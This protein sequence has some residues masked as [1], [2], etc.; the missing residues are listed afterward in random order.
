MDLGGCIMQTFRSLDSLF[1][2]SSVISIRLDTAM[3]FTCEYIRQYCKVSVS[4]P[5]FAFSKDFRYSCDAQVSYNHSLSVYLVR[6]T[7]HYCCT[8]NSPA[9]TVFNSFKSSFDQ[10]QVVHETMADKVTPASSLGKTREPAF[11]PTV[12]FNNSPQTDT[13]VDL[14][15]SFH[16]NEPPTLHS[17]IISPLR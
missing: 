2:S 3:K 12:G 5:L 17:S 6:V 10:R 14:I 13:I 11:E 7:C 9:L 16:M 1:I 15:S 8:I 4:I